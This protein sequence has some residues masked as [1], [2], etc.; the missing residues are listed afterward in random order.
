MTNG[1]SNEYTM[2]VMPRGQRATQ[3]YAVRGV[4]AVTKQPKDAEQN[5]A[6]TTH[7]KCALEYPRSAYRGCRNSDSRAKNCYNSRNITRKITN[8]QLKNNSDI[9]RACVHRD[10]ILNT[11][12]ERI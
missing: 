11:C 10:D 8:L 5:R 3:E 4:V 6:E 1:A 12:C 2:H 7:Q 9:R